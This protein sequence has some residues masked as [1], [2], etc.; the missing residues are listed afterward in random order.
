M[1]R[2]IWK[3]EFNELGDDYLSR[4]G[5]T[6]WWLSLVAVVACIVGIGLAVYLFLGPSGT[7]RL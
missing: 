2:F 4:L 7:P 5:L 1:S 6:V 3:R